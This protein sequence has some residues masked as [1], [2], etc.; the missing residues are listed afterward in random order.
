MNVDSRAFFYGSNGISAAYP[1]G[2]GKHDM[3]VHD[4]ILLRF[5]QI[6]VG[7]FRCVAVSGKHWLLSTKG[8]LIE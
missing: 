1:T 8:P 4:F 5:I 7:A 3:S 2:F 6:R